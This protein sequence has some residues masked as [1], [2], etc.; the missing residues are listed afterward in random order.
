MS[1]LFEDLKH[2]K[3]AEFPKETVIVKVDNVSEYYFSSP[4]E[5]WTDKDFINIAPPFASTWFEWTRPE[6]GN[7]NGKQV[8]MSER[9]CRLGVHV[10]AFDDS[11]GLDNVLDKLR[12]KGTEYS[13]KPKWILMCRG[14]CSYGG[15]RT[16]EVIALALAVNAD[17]TELLTTNGYSFA[18]LASD[19]F[20]QAIELGYAGSG[21]DR[22][23][24]IN[25]LAS[26]YL[27]IPMLA[28]VFM[29][30]SNTELIK[31]PPVP[32]EL[33]KARERRGKPP[34]FRYYTIKVEHIKKVI[35]SSN[36]GSNELSPAALHI[37]RGHFKDFREH[38]LFGKHRGIYWWDMQT[39]G[40]AEVGVI[41]K[42]YDVGGGQ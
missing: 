32:P 20:E 21:M 8:R 25:C 12:K 26:T 11:L 29:H 35:A 3:L 17:G 33:Q 13:H 18:I 14:F 7:I 2:Y 5:T 37:A 24:R 23:Q 40:S 10:L 4:K 42:D 6:M 36:K 9:P 16:G 30:C 41:K 34:L 31:S 1:L 19:N 27:D 15:D 38:G 22:Q 39:R 28:T